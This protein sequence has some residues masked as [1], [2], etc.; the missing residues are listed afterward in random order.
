MRERVPARAQ[1]V[2]TAKSSGFV[3]LDEAAEKTALAWRY[4]PGKRG[5]VPEAMWV[6]VPI[7]WALKKD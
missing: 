2:R 7:K 1:E 4:V 5:G 3:R 6:D